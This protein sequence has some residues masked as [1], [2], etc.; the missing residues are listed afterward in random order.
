MKKS[1]KVNSDLRTQ[2]VDWTVANEVLNAAVEGGRQLQLE[3]LIKNPYVRD[4]SIS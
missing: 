4:T 3:E 1:W 2:D